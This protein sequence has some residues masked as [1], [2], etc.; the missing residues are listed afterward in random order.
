[1][2]HIYALHVTFTFRQRLTIRHAHS[3][4]DKATLTKAKHRVTLQL[5]RTCRKKTEPLARSKLKFLLYGNENISA[6]ER[7][8]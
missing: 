5:C 8:P 3:N 2:H 4:K 7:E 1:M 6:P